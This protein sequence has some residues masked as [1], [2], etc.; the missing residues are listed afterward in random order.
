MAFYPT[1]SAVP[2]ELQTGRPFLQYHERE[3]DEQWR[4]LGWTQLHQG[5][6]R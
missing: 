6:P 2:P 1:G 4:V 5:G 3:H